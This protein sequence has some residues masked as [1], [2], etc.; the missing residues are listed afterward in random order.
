MSDRVKT[1]S[2]EARKLPLAERA[3]LIED[4]LASL[5][6]PDARIDAL[7]AEEAERRVQLVD[8][9]EMPTRDAAQV[10]SELRQ[11]HRG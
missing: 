8:S 11:R 10:I 9:G 1:L 4:L 2:V 5:D 7:W 3:E 6:A